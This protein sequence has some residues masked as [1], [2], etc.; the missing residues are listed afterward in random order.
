MDDRNQKVADSR[1]ALHNHG[2][3]SGCDSTTSSP[4]ILWVLGVRYGTEKRP[5]SGII[6]ANR[7]GAAI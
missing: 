2:R 5:T 6:T 3:A 1:D 4:V 7:A